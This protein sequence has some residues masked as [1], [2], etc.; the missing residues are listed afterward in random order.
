MTQK[1]KA[2]NGNVQFKPSFTQVQNMDRTMRGWCL[3]CGKTQSG[4]EPD[5]RKYKCEACG[6]EK[7][8]G[9]E[10][11]VLMNLVHN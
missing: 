9:P 11:L 5:A 2:R 4:V 8:Y 6:A 1:Y 10:E 3:A 7:V